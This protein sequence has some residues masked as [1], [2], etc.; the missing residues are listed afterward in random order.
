MY[1]DASVA[2][3]YW[4]RRGGPVRQLQNLMSG[5]SE[6]GT[7]IHWITSTNLGGLDSNVESKQEYFLKTSMPKS[8][9]GILL[10][11][12]RKNHAIRETI[13]YLEANHIARLYILLP[14]PW[15]I[16]LARTIVSSTKIE[17]WRGVHDLKRHPG[18]NWPTKRVIRQILKYA[19]V[20]VTFSGYITAQLKHS[21]KEI[22]ESRIVES[23]HLK[24]V[25]AAPGSV[26]FVGRIRT[27]KGLNL[28]KGAW[29]KTKHPN[30]FLTIAGQGRG[31]P[32]RQSSSVRI[33]NRW[34]SDNE[35]E[36]LIDAHSVIVLPYVEASQSGVIPLAHSRGRPVVVTP[37]GGLISQ[38][39][40]G[41]NGIVSAGLTAQDLADAIDKALDVEW[42]FSTEDGGYLPLF[43]NNLIN[44]R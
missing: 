38:V 11:L 40:D 10:N 19:H 22:I 28:L 3:L 31:I 29:S 30:K 18:D 26:L 7:Q 12:H 4:G 32:F 34:L 17:I 41:V 27:Y 15:D 42:N 35:I 33:E 36:S 23:Q 37:V 2:V 43:L 14:H 1:P 21:G 5:A 16:P 25:K 24:N 13:A 39:S 8:K 9:I 44:F 20:Y 6:M